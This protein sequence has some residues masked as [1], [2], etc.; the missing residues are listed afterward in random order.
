MSPRPPQLHGYNSRGIWGARTV[1][2]CGTQAYFFPGALRDNEMGDTAAI[3][4]TPCSCG[5]D[6]Q[7]ISQAAHTG[8]WNNCYTP[9]E[10]SECFLEEV[11]ENQAPEPGVPAWAID[12]HLR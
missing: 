3:S 12:R 11:A 6:E 10:C 9:S 8:G 5:E 4:K 2:G 1:K 7:P